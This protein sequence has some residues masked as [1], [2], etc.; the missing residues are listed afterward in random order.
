MLVQFVS[1]EYAERDAA[2]R[3]VCPRRTLISVL[4]SGKNSPAPLAP[5]HKMATTTSHDPTESTRAELN[6]DQ[7]DE[8]IA[9]FRDY[10]REELGAFVQQY[11]KNTTHF[12]IAFDALQRGV[13][14]TTPGP[15]RTNICVS[16]AYSNSI[17]KVY[18]GEYLTVNAA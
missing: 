2:G 17:V 11:P 3:L 6:K 10:Y 18:N 7:F 8:L 9:F 16:F 14:I 13:S 5:P 15:N 4:L 1:A 12:P